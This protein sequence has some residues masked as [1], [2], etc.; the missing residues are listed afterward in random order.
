L[1][2]FIFVMLLQNNF[3]DVKRVIMNR[4]SKKDK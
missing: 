4:K 1:L 2:Q 3:D